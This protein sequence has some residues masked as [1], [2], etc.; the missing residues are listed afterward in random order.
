MQI[1]IKRDAQNP[2]ICNYEKFEFRLFDSF[3]FG[4]IGIVDRSRAIF[5]NFEYVTAL[6]VRWPQLVTS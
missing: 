2:I 1:D 5:A 3:F 6:D 4:A